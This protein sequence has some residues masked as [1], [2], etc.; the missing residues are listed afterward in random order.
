MRFQNSKE[1]FSCLTI[2]ILTSYKDQF[3]ENE[4]VIVY[5]LDIFG[6]FGVVRK[7]I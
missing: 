5:I 6:C 1:R 7:K 4:M 2:F 3:H